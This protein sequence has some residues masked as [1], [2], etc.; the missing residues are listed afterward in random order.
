MFL[1]LPTGCLRWSSQQSCSP[2]PAGHEGTGRERA[3]NR[4][5]EVH[6]QKPNLALGCLV[7]SD[8]LVQFCGG[9]TACTLVAGRFPQASGG[10][11]C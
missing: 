9:V 11:T 2:S 1:A 10:L 7:I 5:P 6:I 4:G 3:L 8:D